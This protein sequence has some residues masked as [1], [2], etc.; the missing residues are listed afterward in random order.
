[1]NEQNRTAAQQQQQQESTVDKAVKSAKEKTAPVRDTVQEKSQEAMHKAK[2]TANKAAGEAQ[3]MLAGQKREAARQL[4]G[5]AT[6][7]RKT[8]EH[9]ETRDQG[10]F[11]NYSHEVADQIDR[12]SGYLQERDLNELVDDAK[13][14]ARSQPELFI[15]GAFTVGL[16]AARFLRSSSPERPYREYSEYEN[17]YTAPRP[18]TTSTTRV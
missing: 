18:V 3:T 6:S 8:G 9:L 1:M 13:S 14:F 17:R 10:T 2:S 7:L 12:A 15:G 16:L 4:H 5:L 11:A